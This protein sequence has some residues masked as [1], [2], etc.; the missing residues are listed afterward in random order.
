MV[1]NR[2]EEAGELHGRA[3]NCAT[4]ALEGRSK[5]GGPRPCQSSWSKLW[6]GRLGRQ[7][8]RGCVAATVLCLLWLVPNTGAASPAPASSGAVNQLANDL[9]DL[10]SQTPAPDLLP[11]NSDDARRRR[12][13]AEDVLY[14]RLA[15]IDA[16]RLQDA[17]RTTYEML[18]ETLEAERGLRAC[19]RELWGIDHISGWHI[20]LP[21]LA[22]RQA[23]GADEARKAALRRWRQVPGFVAIEIAKLRTGLKL[24]YSVPKPIVVR[25]IA[26]LDAALAQPIEQSSYYSP[27]R[28]DSDAAFQGA[29]A[30]VIRNDIR[31]ALRRYRDFL[32]SSYL[33]SARDTI[34]VSALPNG[35]ACYL[36]LVRHETTLRA[37]PEEILAS[38]QRLIESNRA[39]VEAIGAT[40][41]GE[42]DYATILKKYEAA[43][44][45]RFQSA[46][47][48]LRF[49]TA[50][51]EKAKTRSAPL[52]S[53]LPDL[54]VVVEPF[55]AYL[56]GSGMHPYYEPPEAPGRPARYLVNP[57]TWRA[58]TKGFVEVI[59]VHEGW[60]GH[61][62]Q[63]TVARSLKHS[64]RF[65]ENAV[66]AAFAE[67][68]ARYIERLA[69]EA[70]LYDTPYARIAWRIK[71]GFGMVVDPGLHRFGW[72][73]A[74]AAA[75]LRSSG[76]FPNDQSIDDMIDR[77]T[78]MPAQLTAYDTGGTE[79][80]ELREEAKRR[81]GTR[82][83][84]RRFHDA[85]LSSGFVPL[86][87]LRRR[88]TDWIEAEAR[89]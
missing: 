8:G 79:F 54:D 51:V 36:A 29:L 22:T 66:Y 68:W 88:V 46:D 24:G 75:F 7:S 50:V 84:L 82:F 40:L 42:Q 48:A 83:D 52:F 20:A 70:G 76:L 14:A 74:K 21:A 60:P 12:A 16:D 89:R 32:S 80:L 39:A 45:N 44:E 19:R 53:R 59:A 3:S 65:A 55:P 58:D 15:T 41:F 78:V 85:V 81:L 87:T 67:G 49:A 10:Q 18:R 38:G 86:S 56:S 11:D 69:D 71:P 28:R 77:I 27:A 13:A 25:V 23:V 73:R 2:M 33:P 63:V 37:A 62:L 30:A 72:S 31:P 43:A 26:Q 64:N 47:E 61:H 4:A 34:G 1:D 57:E 17:D 6:R 5:P 35:E 9:Y